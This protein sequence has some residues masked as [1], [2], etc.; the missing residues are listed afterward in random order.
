M[1]SIELKGGYRTTPEYTLGGAKYTNQGA[2]GEGG[3]IYR[4]FTCMQL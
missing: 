4:S 2:L 3:Y 1:Y